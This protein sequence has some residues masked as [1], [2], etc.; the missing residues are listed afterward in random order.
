[1][2]SW[3][4]MMIVLGVLTGCG[5][6]SSD[7]ATPE[8]DDAPARA[9]EAY[10]TAKTQSDADALRPLLCSAMEAD[11]PR[12][13]ASFASVSGVRTEG[14][15]CRSGTTT[16]GGEVIVACEGNIVATYGAEASEFPLASYRA[17]QEDGEWKWCGEAG[18]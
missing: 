6:G 4:L 17:V 8:A 2:R 9:V 13:A 3:L 15:A 7:A 16:T 12:E 14:M 1:M 18:S 11:L 5:G 10:L